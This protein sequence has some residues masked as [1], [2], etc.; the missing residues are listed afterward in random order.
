MIKIFKK[1][2]KNKFT[3]PGT[4][5]YSGQ[6]AIAQTNIS[7]LSYDTN[8]ID[9]HNKMTSESF[10]GLSFENRVNW[11]NIEGLANEAEIKNIGKVF[12]IHPLALEDAMNPSQRPKWESYEDF[13]FLIIP[14]IQYNKSTNSLDSEQFSIVLKKNLVIT[15]Q[16]KKADVVDRIQDRIKKGNGRI[17]K[18]Q[19]DYLVYA[20]LD[21]IIDHYFLIM[22]AMNDKLEELENELFVNPTQDLLQE[23]HQIRNELIF[24]RKSIWPVRD[25]IHK[26]LQEKS[27]RISKQVHLYIRDLN[28][29][30]FQTIDSI[31][32]FRDIVNGLLD[33]YLSSVSN[34]MNE[35]MKIL[36]VFAAIFIPLTFLAGV[37]GMNFEKMPELHYHYSYP[38]WWAI[39]IFV[40]VGMILFFK[41]KKWF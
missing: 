30:L 23:I 21:T 7:L 6:S 22:E 39:S 14:M 18:M 34:K 20:I 15:F 24:L 36:T 17:R 16:D 37:Y 26:I 2:E 29:H 3:V 35:V 40:L 33:L 10:S 9:E 27:D 31:S 32:S 38:I 28:D 12:S 1:I 13:D 41:K 11:I 8:S 25:M 4:I 19:A 5:Q